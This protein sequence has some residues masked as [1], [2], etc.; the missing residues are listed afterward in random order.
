MNGTSSGTLDTVK[1]I[2][3]LFFKYAFIDQTYQKVRR[4]E[5]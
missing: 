2:H 3:H 1:F 4:G 5:S